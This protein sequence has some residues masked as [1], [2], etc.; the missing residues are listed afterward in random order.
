MSCAREGGR[1]RTPRLVPTAKMEPVVGYSGSSIP[2]RRMQVAK[3]NPGRVRLEAGD[4]CVAG[5]DIAPWTMIVM[6]AVRAVPPWAAVPRRRVG[7][8]RRSHPAPCA[9]HGVPPNAQEA[10]PPPAHG[11]VA[12]ATQR[13]AIHRAT[14]TARLLPWPWPRPNPLGKAQKF[15]QFIL[16]QSNRFALRYA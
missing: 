10:A 16:S 14:H 7:G 4:R 13:R 6:A 12:T 11:R 3:S 1:W 2:Y 8:R 9:A 5:L 15:L